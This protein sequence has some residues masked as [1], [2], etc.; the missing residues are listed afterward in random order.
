M[1][2]RQEKNKRLDQANIEEAYKTLRE[3]VKSAPGTVE[4]LKKNGSKEDLK[5]YLSKIKMVIK[6]MQDIESALRETEQ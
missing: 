1:S 4:E 3:W 5:K 2:D 6:K